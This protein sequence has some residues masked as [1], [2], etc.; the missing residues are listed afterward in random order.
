[1]NNFVVGEIVELYFE[2]KRVLGNGSLVQ[3]LE[4]RGEWAVVT[5]GCGQWLENL[6]NLRKV[7]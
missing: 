4:L 5:T 3:I 7:S 2:K 6:T 1:M